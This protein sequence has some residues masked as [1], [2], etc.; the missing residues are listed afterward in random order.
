MSKI[1]IEFADGKT[2]TVSKLDSE[3][4]EILQRYNGAIVKIDGQPSAFWGMTDVEIQKELNRITT[5]TTKQLKTMSTYKCTNSF[6]GQTGKHFS[7]GEKISQLEFRLLPLSEQSNFTLLM[8][9][10]S[11]NSNTHTE[12]N[13]AITIAE[14]FFNNDTI[15][16]SSNDS[17]A[18]SNNDSSSGSDFG[19]G[20][21]GGGGG[22]GDW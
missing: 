8:E 19:G 11:S 4:F 12:Y 16:T 10:N 18:S 5:I 9:E 22:G 2:T 14:T 3:I 1:E 21:F 17:S 6:K 7:Y 20:D 13:G 15:D